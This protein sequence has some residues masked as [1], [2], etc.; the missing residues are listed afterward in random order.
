VILLVSFVRS[1]P[2]NGCERVTCREWFRDLAELR[3]F[4]REVSPLGNPIANPKKSHKTRL[5]DY[6]RAKGVGDEK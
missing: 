1:L 6:Q 4:V 2:R 5:A 3:A